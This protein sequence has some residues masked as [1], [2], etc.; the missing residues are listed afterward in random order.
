MNDAAA[1]VMSTLQMLFTP[2]HGLWPQLPN[3]WDA[4]KD[5][6]PGTPEHARVETLSA[7][8]AAA[9]A[10]LHAEI[11]RPE[12]VMLIARL[13]IQ[14]QYMTILWILI[15]CNVPVKMVKPQH[16]IKARAGI[17]K[18]TAVFIPDA[19]FALLD[20]FKNAV[21]MPPPLHPF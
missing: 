8:C 17:I 5:A 6:A 16:E 13:R 1:H 18:S 10:D 21:A 3:D 4:I 12:L 20:V 15:K 11:L 7:A 19:F 2:A 14:S 9:R